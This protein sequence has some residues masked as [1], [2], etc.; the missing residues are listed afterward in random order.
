MAFARSMRLAVGA[1]LL[2]GCSA[3][4][5]APVPDEPEP[6]NT[7]QLVASEP[8]ADPGDAAALCPPAFTACGGDPTGSWQV[9]ATCGTADPPQMDPG[10]CAGISAFAPDADEWTG[11]FFARPPQPSTAALQGLV[12]FNADHSYQSVIGGSTEGTYHFDPSCLDVLQAQDC[13]A[14]TATLVTVSTPNYQDLSCTPASQGCDC[15]YRYLH[16]WADQGTWGVQ[17]GKV[18]FVS[19]TTITSTSLTTTTTADLCVAGATLQ[20]GAPDS[21]GAAGQG[22]WLFGGE[23]QTLR[24]TWQPDASM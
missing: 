23:F 2:L 19:S 15:S 12:T 17:N 5:A 10:P 16:D 20:I 22:T 4:I 3:K 6:L 13:N 1:S 24:L 14:L 9:L 18:T 8:D 21:G 7:V 11:G